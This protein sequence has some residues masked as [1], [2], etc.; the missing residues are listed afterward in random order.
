MVEE[1]LFAPIEGKPSTGSIAATLE[2]AELQQKAREE[3]RE[4]WR[5]LED[6]VS[7]R[8]KARMVTVSLT[9]S[10]E[11]QQRLPSEGVRWLYLRNECKRIL[12]GRMDME[13]LLFDEKMDL[14]AISHQTAVLIPPP[15]SP[16]QR[17]SISVDIA[18]ISFVD[19]N[20]LLPL[21]I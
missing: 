16:R 21:E 10:T 20:K 19:E 3:G 9:L 5:A 8:L 6:D 15:A 13:A 17:R 14:I 1:N 18:C 7:K 2:F 4:D 11:I 12:N